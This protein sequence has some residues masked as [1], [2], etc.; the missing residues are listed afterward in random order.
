M[1]LSVLIAQVAKR[2]LKLQ[3]RLESSY[4]IRVARSVA[5]TLGATAATLLQLEFNTYLP[6]KAPLQNVFHQLQLRDSRTDA[7]LARMYDLFIRADISGLSAYAFME[8]YAYEYML[9]NRAMSRSLR[10]TDVPTASSF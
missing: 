9:I 10:L 3:N 5:N 7:Q 8:I 2:T 1:T 6:R 4:L